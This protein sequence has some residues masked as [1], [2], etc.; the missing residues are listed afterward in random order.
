MAT[1]VNNPKYGEDHKVVLK[2]KNSSVVLEKF[3]KF[4]YLPES[5]VF[6]ITV[7]TSA[8]T[9]KKYNLIDLGGGN[10]T[11][12]FNDPSK[13]LVKVKGSKSA[14]NSIFNHFS[15]KGK[16]N[17]GLLTEIKENISMWIFESYIENNK[18][19]SENQIIEKL[20]T[21]KKYY[22]TVYY[23]SAVMQAKELKSYLKSMKGYSYERQQKN[24]TKLIYEKARKFT[25]KQADNWNPAD[26]WMIKK[27]FAF[28]NMV[29]IS[30]N[31]NELNEKLSDA[32]FKKQVVPISL[33]QVTKKAKIKLIDPA[34]QLNEKL[35]IDLSFES[36][37]ISE[38]FNNFIIWTK[39]GF[40]IRAG[41]KASSTT[42]NVSLEGRFKNAGYQTGAVDAKAYAQ[43]VEK[44]HHYKLRNSST[45]NL[46][47][48]FNIAA[49]ELK[50]IFKN[51][52]KISSGITSEQNALDLVNS[53]DDLTKKR[54][55]NLMS[56]LHTFMDNKDKFNDHMKFC[57]Y[58]SKKI[59]SDNSPY[60]IIE[61]G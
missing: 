18:L 32:V 28:E 55:C 43:H 42:L 30:T 49:K 8:K 44:M 7:K 40:G 59:S 35:N 12:F 14:L 3:K 15:D 10:D 25:G 29:K 9:A 27:G 24:I 33:K 17:T 5:T 50:N 38:S 31:T 20:G 6:S 34:K 53:S 39:S 46:S 48:E 45:V 13:N 56:S 51:K 47:S 57:Y 52:P 23:D 1:I 60:V 4:N 41:F 54:F 2:S 22:S 61:E 11:V 19:L 21:N 26:V 37:A 36:L 16:S 58:T